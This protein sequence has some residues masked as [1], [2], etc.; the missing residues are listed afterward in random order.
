MLWLQPFDGYGRG[1]DTKREESCGCAAKLVER[2]DVQPVKSKLWLVA[3]TFQWWKRSV[4]HAAPNGPVYRLHIL[5]KFT[6]DRRFSSPA[7]AVS[8]W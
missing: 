1:R 7:G 5:M 2:Q 8:H 6:F 4:E 3:A